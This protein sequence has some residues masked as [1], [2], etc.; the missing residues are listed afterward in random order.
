MFISSR[1]QS[2]D[3][4]TVFQQSELTSSLPANVK[5]LSLEQWDNSS[6]LLRLE[7]VYEVHDDP[8]YG[9]PVSVSLKVNN[10]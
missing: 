4:N 3:D 2:C 10:S 9:K 7:H 6:V 5:L 1:I 8:V